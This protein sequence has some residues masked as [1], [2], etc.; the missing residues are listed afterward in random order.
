[1][2]RLSAKFELSLIAACASQILHGE[3]AP[4]LQ[5]AVDDFEVTACV[6]GDPD[7]LVTESGDSIEASRNLVVT[8]TREEAEDIPQIHRHEYFDSRVGP[9][10]TAALE[11]ANRLVRFLKHKLHAP[12][13]NL[14]T[15]K[16]FDFNWPTWLDSNGLAI[17]S[18]VV[19]LNSPLPPGIGGKLR[20][21]PFLVENWTPAKESV[22]NPYEPPLQQVLLSDAQSAW[23]AKDMRRTIIDTAIAVEVMVKRRYFAG[24]SPAGLA[25]DYLEDKGK[26]TA[27][28]L[29]LIDRIAVVAFGR[30]Y[31]LEEPKH[32]NAIDHLFRCRNKVVHRGQLIFNDDA[33]VFH[34]AS[35]EVVASWWEAAQDLDAWLQAAVVSS[36]SSKA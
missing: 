32:F 27:K 28:V 30:S 9:Y 33:G 35:P 16:E 26:V 11:M 14:F 21:R 36:T 12:Y 18:G 3:V 24:S 23:Y 19:H 1:M 15:G 5:A 17:D 7:S 31:K 25:F 13:L 10:R 29:D 34:P 4:P 2:H 22:V 8:A 6:F 20:A